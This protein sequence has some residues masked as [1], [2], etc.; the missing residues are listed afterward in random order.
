MLPG[1]AQHSNRIKYRPR[2]LSE[3]L[4]EHMFLTPQ[5]KARGG[6]AQ[7]AQPDGSTADLSDRPVVWCGRAPSSGRA[8]GGIVVGVRRRIEQHRTAPHRT[9]PAVPRFCPVRAARESDRRQAR[10]EARPGGESGAR[11]K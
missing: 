2:D 4:T 6:P 5:T 11:F 8:G 9:G 3:M 10:G 7:T 1:D